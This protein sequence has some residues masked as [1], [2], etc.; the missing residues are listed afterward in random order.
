MIFAIFVADMPLAIEESDLFGFADDT[1]TTTS[2]PTIEE[3]CE[4]AVDDAGRL[5]EYM[6]DNYLVANAEKTKL[7]V[8]RPKR[9]D[10]TPISVNIAGKIVSETPHEKLL[11]LQISSDLSSAVP[12]IMAVSDIWPFCVFLLFWHLVRSIYKIHKE[13]FYYLGKKCLF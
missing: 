10:N 9:G 12:F 5:V 3:A 2:R 1:T 8:I 13:F 6:N 11:G 7:L 4:A